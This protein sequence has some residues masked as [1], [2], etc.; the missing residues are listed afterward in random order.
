[1]T[2]KEE[3]LRFIRKN[4]SANSQEL[5]DHF[6][7]S[8]Q[9]VHKHIKTLVQEQK[10]IKQGVTRGAVYIPASGK[11]QPPPPTRIRKNLKLDGIEEHEVFKTIDLRASLKSQLTQQAYAIFK[12]AF[13]ELLN[14]AI[15]HSFSKDC[16]LQV[17]VDSYSASFTIRD[18][19]IG[20]FHSIFSKF[21]LNDE[22]EALG[23]LLKG[24][25]TTMRERHSGEGIFF[26]SRAADLFVLRSHAITLVFNNLKND[27]FVEQQRSLKGT[28]ATFSI[29][30]S[31]RRDL[32]GIFAQFSPEEFDY[33]FEKTR[34]QVKLFHGDYVSR[35][36]AKRLVS[37][38]EKFSEVVLDFTDVASIG[39]GFADEIFRVFQ[40]EH[41]HIRITSIHA[42]P[43]VQ[44]M[45]THVVDNR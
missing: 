8:K 16:T 36:E 27:V 11:Q 18:F 40:V 30:R 10:I 43:V 19:G 42:N 1:M 14:N 20:I 12:Y 17:G 39:Q 38:L 33:R 2:K 25:T 6:G 15:D 35:S 22:H 26:T 31:S 34:V 3:I 21:G 13:T 29:S 41:P 4:T 5:V 45:I 24:K 23:E 7:I 9:A 28:E 37:G 32:S 44:Q